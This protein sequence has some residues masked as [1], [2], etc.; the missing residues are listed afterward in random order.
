MNKRFEDIIKCDIC[1]RYVAHTMEAPLRCPGRPIK[2]DIIKE[3]NEKNEIEW[4]KFFEANKQHLIDHGF[5]EI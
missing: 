2:S 1:G 5:E 4:K 3:H